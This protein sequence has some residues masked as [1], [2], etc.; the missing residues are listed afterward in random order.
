MPGDATASRVLVIGV[1]NALASDDAVGLLV[2]R[3]LRSDAER[4]GFEVREHEGDVA[5]L[6]ELWR[7]AP[8]V[9]L[10]DA[11]HGAGPPGALRRLDGSHEPLP[12]QLR[13]SSST[14]HLGIAEGVELARVLGRLPARLVLYGIE[15]AC[16][17]AGEGLSRE[18]RAAVEPAARAVLEEARVLAAA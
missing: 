15:G 11:L 17:G 13:G 7:G 8:A 5:G 18:V 3:R 2:A 6:L 9:V 12:V 16:F 14:H 10:I 1:G 4:A